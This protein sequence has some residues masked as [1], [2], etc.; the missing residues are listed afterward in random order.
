MFEALKRIY[1][2][3]Q[4]EVY[5]TNAVKKKYITAE[6]KKLIMAEYA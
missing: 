3:T 4:S 6:E 5:L 1:A 2:K